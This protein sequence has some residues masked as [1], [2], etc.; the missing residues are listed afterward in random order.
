MIFKLEN[1]K[2]QRTAIHGVVKEGH[3][4]NIC[5]SANE[6]GFITLRI[7]VRR[8]MNRCSYFEAIM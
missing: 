1:L 7:Y 4:G 8:P 2:H 3:S 6:A 5:S